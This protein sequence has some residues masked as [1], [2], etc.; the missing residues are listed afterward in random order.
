M[1]KL[2]KIFFPND[3][4]TSSRQNQRQKKICYHLFKHL[5]SVAQL[6]QK[7][8]EREILIREKME[9]CRKGQIG[10]TFTCRW[11]KKQSWKQRQ[12]AAT[13][14]IRSEKFD[15]LLIIF[16]NKQFREERSSISDKHKAQALHS[17]LLF[18]FQYYIF[19][20]DSIKGHQR[21]RKQI[22]FI[23]YYTY[24]INEQ[25]RTQKK[26]ASAID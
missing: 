7:E 26:Y 17:L 20:Y 19:I 1:D 5:N 8:R 13:L 9:Y 11:K 23:I 10:V 12:E 2:S 14:W 25:S 22:P 3:C 21:L 18:P 4:T 16:S 6:Q 15:T 24:I